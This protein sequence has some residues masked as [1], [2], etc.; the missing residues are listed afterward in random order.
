MHSEQTSIVLSRIILIHT[1]KVR[2]LNQKT[3]ATNLSH[4]LFLLTNDVQK[5]FAQTLSIQDIVIIW[6]H[7]VVFNNISEHRSNFEEGLYQ[8]EVGSCL[9]FLL[10]ETRLFKQGH[11]IASIIHPKTR[12]DI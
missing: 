8:I 12:E 11:L 3:W 5:L 1:L 10:S 7:R 2:S 6:G 9:F 4:M